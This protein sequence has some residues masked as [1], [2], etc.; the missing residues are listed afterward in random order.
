[1]TGNYRAG[2]LD[3]IRVM[4]EECAA[5]AGCSIYDVEWVGRA[6]RVTLDRDVEGGVSIE[7]CSNVSREL[8][9]RLDSF[10]G[11]PDGS[12][13]LEV[14]SPGLERVL[15]EKRHFERVIG[16]K[17]AVKSFVPLLELN[18]SVPELG[19]AKQI[20]G[21]LLGIDDRG[22]RVAFGE[23]EPYREVIVPMASVTKAHVVFEF[24]EPK[25]PQK[26]GSK[27]PKKAK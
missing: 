7:D 4:A 14:S 18:P 8:N 22:V 21:A 26:N 27:G 3:Q 17:I 2:F 6:L 24:E 19:K 11:L 10:E 13:D 16:K 23:V 20:Q 15:K 12:F 25:G 5:A 9:Q 1:L